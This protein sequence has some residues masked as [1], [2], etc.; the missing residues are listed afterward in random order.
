[1][2]ETNETVDLWG[3]IITEPV[4]TPLSI[5]KEQGAFLERKTNG[6]LTAEIRS[7]SKGGAFTHAF[8]LKSPSLNYSYMLFDV[9]HALTLYP[10]TLS[11]FDDEENFDEA[12]EDIEDEKEFIGV[13]KNVL[14]SPRTQ[15]IISALISQSTGV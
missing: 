12:I 2:A 15:K 11:V 7:T 5:L 3:D 14:Q 6:I 10:A 1:M 13:L 4:R 9:D 8:Y